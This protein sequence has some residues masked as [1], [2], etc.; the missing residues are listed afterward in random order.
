MTEGPQ[1]LGTAVGHVPGAPADVVAA[2]LRV[3][4]CAGRVRQL[5]QSAVAELL[6]GEVT[7]AV[8]G[9]RELLRRIDVVGLRLGECGDVLSDAMQKRSH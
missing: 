2:T 3:G 4:R 9:R 7:P 8:L 1:L 6:R 5:C